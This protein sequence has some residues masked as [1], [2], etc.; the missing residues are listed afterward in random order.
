MEIVD[1]KPYIEQVKTRL[2]EY[3]TAL[4]RNLEFQDIEDEISNPAKK[5]TPPAGKLLV[6]YEKGTVLGMVAYHRISDTRCEMKRLYVDPKYRGQ[7]LGEKLVGEIIKLAK[8]AGYSEMVLDTLLPMKAAIEIYRK[9]GFE[10][11]EPYYNNPM[12]DVIY[13]RKTL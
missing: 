3:V 12:D 10:E 5:Y 9:Y 11:C 8:D 4:G 2:S 7:H 6:A 13:M 1:G